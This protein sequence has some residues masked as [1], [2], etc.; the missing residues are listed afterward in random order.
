MFDRLWGRIEKAESK[1][2][3]RFG[4]SLDTP[5]QRFLSHI[6]FQLMDHGFLRII[7]T[8]FYQFA[9]GAYRSNQPSPRRIKKYADR[10]IRTIVNLRGSP[11]QSHF[12]LEKEACKKFGVELIN[13][14]MWARSLTPKH[15]IIELFD[16]FDKIE[17]PFVVH[18]KSGADRASLAAAFYLI[19]SQGYTVSETRNQFSLKYLHLK[20][21]RTGVLD[22]LMDVYEKEGEAKNISLRDW[23][24][25]HYDAEALT[26]QFL[27]N[28]G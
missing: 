22:F 21:S 24:T 11:S 20:F 14:S 15:F 25:S 5:W 19:Y 28:R 27:I 4:N 12:L 7:W 10:G 3:N 6:H 23:I 9:P 17:K 2:R 13:C 18:C 26:D 8:N 16:V 1:L